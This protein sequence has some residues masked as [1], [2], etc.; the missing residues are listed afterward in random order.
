MQLPPD[1]A[2][3]KLQVA[4]VSVGRIEESQD[5]VRFLIMKGQYELNPVRLR[6]SV[7]TGPNEKSSVLDVQGRGQDVWG[8]ASRR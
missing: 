6:I 2:W 4:A 8:V 1:E 3:E 7:L 5:L